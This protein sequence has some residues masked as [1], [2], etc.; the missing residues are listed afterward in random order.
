MTNVITCRLPEYEADLFRHYAAHR[1]VLVSHA[2]RELVN[3][4]IREAV[5]A[6]VSPL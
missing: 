3:R 5:R 6:V 1:G 4:E 2:I